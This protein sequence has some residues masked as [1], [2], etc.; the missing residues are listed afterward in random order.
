MTALTRFLTIALAICVPCAAIAQS[1]DHGD[2]RATAT[3]LNYDIAESGSLESPG[4]VDYFR[5]DLQG[6]ASVE[7]RSTMDLDTVGTLFDS[8][9]TEV[10]TADDIDLAAGNFN[11]R[12]TEELERGV[13]YLEVA[14][15]ASSTG[16]Y[17]VLARFDLAG[18]DHGDSFGASSILPLG[19]RV[20]GSVNNPDDVD[21][22][23]IDFPVSTFAEVRTVSQHP[24]STN[25]YIPQDDGSL[26]F[27]D[28]GAEPLRDQVWHGT[29]HG[30]YYFEVSGAVSA[31][32]I[33][34][35]AEN[36]GCDV[37]ASQSTPAIQGKTA[38]T[39]QFRAGS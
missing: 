12:I 13:Y 35:N 23:R 24:I 11:F 26:E 8:E 37:A 29:W 2:N 34:A 7:F 39:I 33:R 15:S 18:D 31:F 28:A 30:T 10:S 36:T 25:L 38:H 32:N 9:G 21:W 4:D 20:A 22:F 3:R 5:I 17:Q 6:R 16:D 19:P 27:F 1:D 14:G